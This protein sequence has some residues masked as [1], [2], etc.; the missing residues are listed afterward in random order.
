MQRQHNEIRRT[1]LETAN[2]AAIEVASGRHRED[3]GNIIRYNRVSDTRGMGVN[4]AGEIQSPFASWGILLDSYAS[5][6]T[7]LGNEVSGVLAGKKKV[8]TTPGKK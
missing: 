3:T 7:V 1:C 6:T 5:G 8:R 4:T 2:G